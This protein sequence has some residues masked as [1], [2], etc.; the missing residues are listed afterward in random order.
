MVEECLCD[1]DTERNIGHSRDGKW[2]LVPAE[3]FIDCEIYQILQN[4]RF[5]QL[6]ALE[7]ITMG[8]WRRKSKNDKRN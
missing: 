1:I 3:E 4:Y 2:V 8:A 5:N 6:K 7:E